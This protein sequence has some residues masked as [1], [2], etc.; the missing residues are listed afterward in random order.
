MSTSTED[1]RADDYAHSIVPPE[2]RA[3]R[4][5]LTMAS[6]SLISAMAWLF[7]GALAATLTGTRQALIGLLV[8][9][10]L[11]SLVN[12]PL[13]RLAASSG[14]NSAL[15]S[16]R[17]FGRAGSVLIALL[18]AAT[19]VYFAVFEGSVVAE[20]FHQ[21]WG[22]DIRWWY[23]IVVIGMLPLMMG[24]I[25]TWM[26]KLNGVLLP[27]YVVG[28]T[29]AVILAARQGEPGR[30]LDFP[31]VVPEAARTLPGWL[32]TVILYLGVWLVMPTT[33]DFAR[34]ARTDDVRYHQTVTFGWVFSAG[35][36]LVNGAAGMFLV[37]MVLPGTTI[38]AENG[39]VTAL[40]GPLGLA[41]VLLI[42]V[43]QIRIN[44]LNFYQA[45]MNLQRLLR[46]LVRVHAP[47]PVV[48]VGVGALVFVLMLTDVFSYL[49]LALQWQGT[50]FVGWVGIVLTHL[51]L[52]A[53]WRT[54]DVPVKPAFCVWVVSAA[55]GIVLIQTGYEAAP[56]V[57]LAL[58]VI[59]YL[60]IAKRHARAP[61][62][63]ETEHTG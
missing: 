23:L 36:F 37:Q 51:S 55:V 40:V 1:E 52:R 10:V 50:F 42:V 46:Q 3:P 5:S 29:A 47:R 16:A 31:G 15:V 28:M 38:A 49:Q 32:T 11:F 59:G 34:F 18:L 12:S 35:I 61:A 26:G 63:A 62:P 54:D 44:T 45:S 57:S 22:M 33:V 14:L 7:Y 58:A 17:L 13:V 25:L 24:G 21:Y 20:A 60:P 6:W 9:V 27:L 39:V 56:L 30:F 8:S 19:T 48:V 53:P 43:T 41:G 4:M 2:A